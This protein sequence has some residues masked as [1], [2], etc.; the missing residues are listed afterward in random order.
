METGVV[1]QASQEASG[2]AQVGKGNYA[3]SAQQSDSGQEE[4]ED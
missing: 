1:H 3:L 4:E 2:W